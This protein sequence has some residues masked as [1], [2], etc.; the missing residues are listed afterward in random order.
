MISNIGSA[1][2]SQTVA[3]CMVLPGTESGSRTERWAEVLTRCRKIRSPSRLAVTSM[4]WSEQHTG[5]AHVPV[6][7]PKSAMT[8][9]TGMRK[10]VPDQ[11]GVGSRIALTC[12][13]FPKKSAQVAISRRSL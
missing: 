7:P 6:W 3:S 11:T 8:C 10:G 12:Q 9:P 1:A 4:L 2:I 13:R 5:I